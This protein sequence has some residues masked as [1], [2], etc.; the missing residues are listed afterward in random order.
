MT[1][2]FLLFSL[3]FP[4]ITLAYCWITHMIP[5]AQPS[6]SVT[7]VSGIIA[8]RLLIAFWIMAQENINFFGLDRMFV[9]ALFLVAQFAEFIYFIRSRR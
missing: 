1:E 6:E 5:P 7:F 3:I 4:R 2:E 9:V 8:P